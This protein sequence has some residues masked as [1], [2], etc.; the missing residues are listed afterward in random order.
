MKIEIDL[1]K[2][3]VNGKGEALRSFVF[4]EKLIKS[5]YGE[6]TETGCYSTFE[7]NKGFEKID[8]D[9]Y[10]AI[11]AISDPCGSDIEAYE[12]KD[13]VAMWWWD[14]DGDLT[15]W[16]KGEKFA[17]HNSDCK[18]DYEWREIEVK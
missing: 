3:G 6:Y 2:L 8:P 18:C 16:I 10:P 11:K 5:R 9:K 14:G 15:I 7:V 12:S 13:V 1:D 4:D 17:Y